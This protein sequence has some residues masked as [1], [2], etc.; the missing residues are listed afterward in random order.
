MH[1]RT[2]VIT[3]LFPM[4][5]IRDE[6]HDLSLTI[7]RRTHDREMVTDRLVEVIFLHSSVA[8]RQLEA[9]LLVRC[10]SVQCLLA[11]RREGE[12]AGKYR[13]SSRLRSPTSKAG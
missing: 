5:S 4:K 8:C 6:E 9:G 1:R 2:R 11:T 7:S 10:C 12:V 3:D 13:Y